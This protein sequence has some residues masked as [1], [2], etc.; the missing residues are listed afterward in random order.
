M[1]V[2]RLIKASIPLLLIA[3]G[4]LWP[5][6]FTGGSGDGPA[7]EDPVVISDYR[8]TATVDAAGD[9]TAV[10]TITAQVYTTDRHGIFRYWDMANRNDSHLRQP[11][12][13]TSIALDGA[14]VPY[15]MLWE[16]GRRFRV[17]KIGD[18]DRTLSDGGHVFEIAYRIRG[19]LDPGATGA[20]HRFAQTVGAQESSP[21]V[22]FW[23]VIAPSWNNRIDRAEISVRLP[24]A[25]GAVQCSVGA[26][27]GRACDDLRASGDTVVATASQLPPRTPVTLRAGVD[28]QTPLRSTL[29]WP[30]TWDRILGQSVT[31][32]LWLL[33]LTLAAGA[34]AVLWLRSVTE[35]SPGF[36]LQY[37]PPPGLG[38]VQVEY[39][40]TEAV[41]ENGLT[42]TLFYLAERKLI[43]L[44]QLGDKEWRL[45]SIA[46]PGQW[47]GLD[48]V[49]LA[50]A[51]R[52]KLMNSGSEFTAKKTATSGQ[53]LSKAKEDMTKAVLAWARDG[54]LLVARRKELWLRAAN[55]VAF[56]LMLCG[57]FRWGF[58]IT[59]WAL[60]F[61]VFFVLTAASW[62]DGVGFR[63]TAAGRELWSRAGGFHRVLATDSAETRFD[64][65][66]RRDLYTAYVP[67]A[68]AG[69]VAAAWAKK[70]QA[71]TNTAAP[72]PDWYVSS[73]PS[74]SYSAAG[75]SGGANFDSF[76]SALSSSIG[77]YTASQSS[78]SSSSSG[79]GGGFSGGGGGGG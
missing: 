23:N 65:A 1:S 26:G 31:G 38:P 24:G 37:A 39:I 19:V 58:P 28:V 6:L 7:L 9:M 71:Y 45:R 40:R 72:Q 5:L 44:Q 42:A 32:A 41:P 70:Y 59:L 74:T 4:L 25:V 79:G 67:F 73:S 13:I 30:Y 63:R 76:E 29:P 53:K 22:F 15:Q 12:E 35:P 57:F 36:P 50:V 34:G 78:S 56:L 51:S 20:D 68:V 62:R 17:A 69:G 14:P 46:E 52:L 54:G 77:A 55:A 43:T 8:M 11:P 3:F 48:P 27:V 49:T 21:S 18:P 33:G 66:A 60:P 2:R 47:S 75:S 10:E 61:A 64:F 16:D